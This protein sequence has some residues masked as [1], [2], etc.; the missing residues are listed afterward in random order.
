M[1]W[2]ARLKGTPATE[3]EI[4]HGVLND[5]HGDSHAFF[6]IRDP[7]WVTT[8]PTDDQAG[9]EARSSAT[10]RSQSLSREAT[11]PRRRHAMIGSKI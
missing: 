6:Y 8:R 7:A 3:T 10:K 2:L 5:P 1:P 4:F 11:P 9:L